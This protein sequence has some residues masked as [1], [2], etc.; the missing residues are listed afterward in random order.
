MTDEMES[1]MHEP[2][3]VLVVGAGLTGLSTAFFLRQSGLKVAVVEEKPRVGGQI[4]TYREDDFIFESGPNTGAISY[5][6]VVELF[7]ALEP[8]CSLVTAHDEAKK[9][10][11]W[12]GQRFMPLPSGLIQAVTTPLFTFTDKLR[13]LGEPWRAPGTDPDESVAQLAAR[14]LG[15]SF[16]DYAVDPFLSGVYAGNPEKLVT[17]Y[18]LPKLYNLEQN[19]GS[20]IKGTIAKA[21]QQKT[22]RER[23]ATKKVFS[24]AGG[25]NRLID[26]MASRLESS[27]IHTDVRQV[28][29]CPVKNASAGKPRWQ[30]NWLYK[31]QKHHV[32]AHHVVTTVGSYRLPDLMPFLPLSEMKHLNNLNYAPVMQVAAG[33]KHEQ[34]PSFQVFGGLVPSRECRDVLGILNPSACFDGRAPKG[35]NMLAIFM[36][37]VRRPDLLE[38]SDNQIE[39]MVQKN[40]RE[41][42]GAGHRPDL[43]R[44]FRHQCAIPQYEISS[45]DR[46]A[47]ISRVEQAYP[48]LHIKGNLCGGIGMADRI[49]QAYETA[50][51]IASDSFLKK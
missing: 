38:L 29:V 27:Q 26:A 34:L 8:D 39:I 19:Y 44:I 22:E 16:V 40:L 9:R 36:G 31:E 13:I 28:C 20:F 46:F 3:D 51:V 24:A 5:P 41:M 37:G 35:G 14:R 11:I 2:L 25:L 1:Y 45:G 48:G 12:K 18:A 6:E 50:Q 10:L 30:I 32:E 7:Q 42:L 21:R 23:L 17:R 43:I 4:H 15:R 47:A 33:F 49:H